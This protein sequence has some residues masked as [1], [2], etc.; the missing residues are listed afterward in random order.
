MLLK[1][2]PSAAIAQGAPHEYRQL[3]LGGEVRLVLHAPSAALAD[4]GARVAY[5]VIADLEQ[6]F[7]DWRP[8]SE[9]RRITERAH[10][11]RPASAPLFTL[12]RDALAL[13]RASDGAFDPTVGP[14]VQ[15]WREARR[16]GTLP[17]DTALR[18]ARARTGWRHVHLD[19]RR[20]AMRFDRDAMRLDF[21]GIAKGFILDSALRRLRAMGIASALLEAGGDL[22]LGEAPPGQAGWAIAAAGPRGDTTLVVANVAVSTSGP[23]EQSA[24]IGGVRYSHVLDPR[25]GMALARAMQATV[26]HRDGTL[27]D[28]LSTMITVAGSARGTT[29]ARRLGATVVLLSE[30][31]TTAR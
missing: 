9:A 18:Q 11:W 20:R 27:A 2:H 30:R 4:S 19:V 26:V 23:S 21:G 3:H 24:L 25:T 28:G 10:T 8:S 13:A 16:T 15:L 29:I 6:V 12:T 5:G 31:P 1:L 22:A 7:S 17:S 14:L